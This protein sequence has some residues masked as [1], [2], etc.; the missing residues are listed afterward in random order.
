METMQNN[1]CGC[2]AVTE[3]SKP[4]SSEC[5][6]SNSDCDYACNK[7]S[8]PKWSKENMEYFP[9]GF[10]AENGIFKDISP[11]ETH[12]MIQERNQDQNLVVLDVK[13]EQEYFKIH[14]SDS[15]SMDFFSKSFKDDLFLL[16]KNKIYIVICK[17]GIRSEIAMNLMKKMGF[18]EVYNVLGG[19]ERWI[20][21]E[22]PY[23]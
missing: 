17:V 22:I 1:S 6:S 12:Q 8:D 18:K 23:E 10:A 13:T 4:A 16:D 5:Y 19:D 9:A 21:Q 11:K 14:L 15:R 2:Q 20:A 3:E 7:L